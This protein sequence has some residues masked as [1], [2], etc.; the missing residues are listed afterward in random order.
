MVITLLYIY[1]YWIKIF[2]ITI[3]YYMAVILLIFIITF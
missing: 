2:L 3:C 1:Y